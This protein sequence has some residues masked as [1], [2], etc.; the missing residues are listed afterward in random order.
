[1]LMV[2]TGGGHKNIL[3]FL[4]HKGFFYGSPYTEA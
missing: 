1:M 4:E 2:Q 3:D